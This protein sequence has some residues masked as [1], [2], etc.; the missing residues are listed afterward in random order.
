MATMTDV[1]AGELDHILFDFDWKEQP[2]LLREFLE[3]HRNDAVKLRA[4]EGTL[5]VSRGSEEIT[6]PPRGK[7]VPAEIAI[8]LLLDY[9][10]DGK[11][12]GRDQATMLTQAQFSTKKQDEK[13]LLLENGFRVESRYLYHDPGVEETEEE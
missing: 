7:W 6:V 8:Y 10:R 2:P 4:S 9:G 12:T 11:Y 3:R 1:R 5:K 13:D